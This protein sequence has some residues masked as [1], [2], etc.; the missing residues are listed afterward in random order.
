MPFSLKTAPATFQRLMQQEFSEALG[1]YALVYLDDIIIYSHTFKQHLKHL[2]T[3]L[4]MVQNAGLKVSTSKSFFCR[5]KLKYLRHVV[6]AE[7]ID[8]DDEKV[9]A[10]KETAAP[11]N[12]RG[13]RP[14]LG[15]L[16]YYLRFAKDFLKIAAPL[17]VLTRMNAKFVWTS[18]HDTAFN[19]LRKN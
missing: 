14:V 18:I 2:D 4:R 17:T 8:V 7:G 16:T 9:K 15:M 19:H 1:E 10:M 12:V 5:Q 6:S 11:R 3:V 13:V